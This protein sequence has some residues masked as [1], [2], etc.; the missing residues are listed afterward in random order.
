MPTGETSLPVAQNSRSK[1]FGPHLFIAI[2]LVV[3]R[4]AIVW[5]R[6]IRFTMLILR[7]ILL[8]ESSRWGTCAKGLIVNRCILRFWR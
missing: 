3:P 5:F 6:V 4:R 1:R 7:M 2:L 8:E